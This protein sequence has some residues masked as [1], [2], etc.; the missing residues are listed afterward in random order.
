MDWA[1]L[2]LGMVATV[3]LF[4][5]L[6]FRKTFRSLIGTM[7]KS[8][9]VISSPNIS[10][11]WKEK[12]LLVYAADTLGSSVLLFLLM[13]VAL[14]PVTTLGGVGNLI[15]IDIFGL[16][17]RPAGV[18]MPTVGAVVYAFVRKKVLNARI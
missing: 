5:R 11:H 10:D 15:G 14:L 4:F 9:K 16:I 7:S 6:P 3:E 18:V 17:S 13:L 2:G 1:L 12:I 8:I